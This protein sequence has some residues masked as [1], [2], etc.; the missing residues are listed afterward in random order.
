MAPQMLVLSATI[1]ILSF[2]LMKH[3]ILFATSA[4]YVLRNCEY[5]IKVY[6]H[7]NFFNTYNVSALDTSVRRRGLVG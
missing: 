7:L 2:A 1:I 4:V 5:E 3:H 6:E